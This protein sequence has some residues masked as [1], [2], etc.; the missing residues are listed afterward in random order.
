MARRECLF[1]KLDPRFHYNEGS[2]IDT[3][4]Y[5]CLSATYILNSTKAG[6]F[7]G[8]FADRP[9]SDTFQEAEMEYVGPYTGNDEEL[10][11]EYKMTLVKMV[12][13]L[14]EKGKYNFMKK[15]VLVE[16]EPD[17][18][19]KEN[20]INYFV[21]HDKEFR[22]EIDKRIVQAVLMKK[23]KKEDEMKN[24]KNIWN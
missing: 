6:L 14:M 10:I 13:S 17:P 7:A 1:L 21:M 2:V 15:M 12:N 3:N 24:A 16:E 5:R 9:D 22:K 4:V 23:K 11:L 20:W 19:Q 18:E 8:Q